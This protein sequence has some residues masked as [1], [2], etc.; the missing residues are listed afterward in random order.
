MELRDRFDILIQ[1]VKIA[2]QKGAL[3]LDDA[4]IAKCAINVVEGGSQNLDSAASVFIKITQIGQSKGCYSL[5]DAH[6][7]Y[8]ACDG[9][10]EEIN[11][12][13]QLKHASEAIE[14]IN[15]SLEKTESVI[16]KAVENNAHKKEVEDYGEPDSPTPENK[17]KRNKKGEE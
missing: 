10:F 2:Q 14:K 11:A 8:L 1:S 15:N 13:E 4:Y 3:T 17:N 6:L 12:L 5:R 7:I 9:I 16:Q